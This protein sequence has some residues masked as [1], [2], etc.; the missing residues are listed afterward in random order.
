MVGNVPKLTTPTTSSLDGEILYIPLEFWFNRNAGLALP[1]IALKNNIVGQKSIQ[2]KTFEHCFG[3]NLLGSQ[4]LFSRSIPDASVGLLSPRDKVKLR[5][6]PK[7]LSTN[8]VLKRTLGQDKNLGM[9][10]TSKIPQWTIRSESLSKGQR[11]TTKRLWVARKS[12]LRYS[13]VPIWKDGYK[14]TISRS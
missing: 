1:L 10:K 7:T 4:D 5:E 14:R 2:P 13:L 3:V 8:C 9:V 12:C 11:S 6:T